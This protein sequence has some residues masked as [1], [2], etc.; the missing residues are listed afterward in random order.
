MNRHLLFPVLLAALLSLSPASSMAGFLNDVMKNIT[1][2]PAATAKLDDA[3]VVKGLKEALATGTA[4]AVASVSQTD[5]YFGNQLIKITMPDKLRAAAA[6]LNKF[7]F[8]QDVDEFVLAMNRAAEKAAPKAKK[9]FIAALHAMTIEDAQKILQGGNTSATEYFRDKTSK[10]LFE[11]FKP[12][13]SSSLQNV[14]AV[15]SYR[16]MA[17]SFK[18]IPYAGTLADADLDNYVT[19]KAVDGLFAMIGAEEKKIRT[20]PAARGTELLQKVFA[21]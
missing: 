6:L 15:Q 5:G 18:S 21:K 12:V 16:Q 9:H 3:T 19:A 1:V 11:E 8:R 20:D 2:P 13:V 17:E 4:N 14:G 7:G 10:T